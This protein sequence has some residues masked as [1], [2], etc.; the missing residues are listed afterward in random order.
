MVKLYEGKGGAGV[1]HFAFWHSTGRTDL[2]PHV[3]KHALGGS[4]VY[5]LEPVQEFLKQM[6]PLQQTA[7]N[8]FHIFFPDT[9]A[10]QVTEIL[11]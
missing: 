1:W 11:S 6:A 4:R 3:S 5:Q 9:H 7:A 8:L 2:A 10:R